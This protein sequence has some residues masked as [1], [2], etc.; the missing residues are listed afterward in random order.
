MR[1]FVAIPLSAVA[2]ALVRGIGERNADRF[3]GYR[4]TPPHLVHITMKFIGEVD[5]I[6]A[7][8]ARTAIGS[9]SPGEP[10]SLKFGPAM[11]LGPSNDKRVVAM[12]L[13][14]DVDHLLVLHQKLEDAFARLGFERESRPFLPHLTVARLTKDGQ[15]LKTVP[16]IEPPKPWFF[17]NHICLMKS[18]LGGPE[19]VYETLLQIPMLDPTTM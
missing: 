4:W 9:I 14:G 5:D 1:L 16:K 11:L 19:P 10:I 13:T 7:A 17:L 18:T 2:Q 15:P 12:K 8:A 6:T 3:P